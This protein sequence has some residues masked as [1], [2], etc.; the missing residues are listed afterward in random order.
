MVALC[1]I[2]GKPPSSS[3]DTRDL[4]SSKSQHVLDTFVRLADD[5]G[6]DLGSLHDTTVC[7]KACFRQLEKLL[8]LERKYKTM[9]V[10][11]LAKISGVSAPASEISRQESR[12]RE[13]LY[14]VTLLHYL[15]L[16]IFRD[17]YT[18]YLNTTTELFLYDSTI[19]TNHCQ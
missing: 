15:S 2:C 7:C 16:S 10:S 1:A 13:L 19:T 5:A 12:A 14:E 11:I 3:K 6:K 17:Y 18:D 9:Y 8:E 4:Y